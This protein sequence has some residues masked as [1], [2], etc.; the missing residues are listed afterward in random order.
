MQ[1]IE[2][3]IYATPSGFAV[4]WRARNPTTGRSERRLK[5]FPRETS[6][7][8][9]RAYRDA[10]AAAATA[11]RRRGGRRSPINVR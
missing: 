1:T 7:V 10:R 4:T 3:N 8:A 11:P 6:L 5:R 9:L 2:A